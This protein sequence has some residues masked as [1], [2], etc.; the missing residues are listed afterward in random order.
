MK[1]FFL[2]IR[3]Q[4]KEVIENNISLVLKVIN[5]DNYVLSDVI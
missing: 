4:F 3:K 5:E 1:Q 2:T